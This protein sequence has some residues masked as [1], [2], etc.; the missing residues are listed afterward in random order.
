MPDLVKLHRSNV[1][2]KLSPKASSQIY[3][4]ANNQWPLLS[5]LTSNFGDLG[6]RLTAA[7][8]LVA[9]LA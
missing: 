7:K 4:A 2:I 6:R 8:A 5:S 3:G 1:I 9:G